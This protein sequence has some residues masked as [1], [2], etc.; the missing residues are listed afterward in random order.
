MNGQTLPKTKC[1]AL[2]LEKQHVHQ[3]YD[4]IAKHF[5]GTR[6]SGTRYKPWPKVVD[7]IMSQLPLS[8]LLDVRC[9]NGKCLG[10]SKEIFEI[11]SDYS[12]N[13]ANICR[14]R[15]FETCVTDVTCLPFRN[16]AFDILLCIAVIHHMA[17][18]ERRLKAVSEIVRILRTGGRA[19]VY[20]W[21]MEQELDKTQSKYINSKRQKKATEGK[22]DDHTNDG[23]NVSKTIPKNAEFSNAFEVSQSQSCSSQSTNNWDLIHKSGQASGKQETS[24]HPPSSESLPV[25][26]NRTQL[27]KQDMLVPWQLKTKSKGQLGNDADKERNTFHR[28]YHV[29]K[30]GELESL[31]QKVPDCFVNES[32]YDQGNWCVVLE[33]KSTA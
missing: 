23:E 28:Y 2:E 13:L 4:D 14:G 3:V 8:L 7:F 12:S 20:V 11:G 31:C 22:T 5:S 16:N 27:L 9:G 18:E 29:F 32:Y 33:K 19:L 10:V 17:T 1:E 6:Y 25:H 15:S 30:Q 21:A 26:V 24:S